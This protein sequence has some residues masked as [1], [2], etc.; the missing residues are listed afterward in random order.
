MYRNL[1][2][3]GK[4]LKS[5]LASSSQGVMLIFPPICGI[6]LSNVK[7]EKSHARSRCF[8][9]CVCFGNVPVY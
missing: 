9:L 2:E 8:D 4:L 7:R 3:K 1:V 6:G 5:D